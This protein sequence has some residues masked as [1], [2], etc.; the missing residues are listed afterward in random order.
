MRI[1]LV[2]VAGAL[3]ALCR[4]AVGL[5]AGSAAFPWATLAI[6]VAGS[7][8]LAALLAVAPVPRGDVTVALG[9]GFLGAFTTFSTFSVE[10]LA[11]LRDGRAGA[12]AAYVAASMVLGVAAAGAGWLVGDR[13]V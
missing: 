12:A 13:L 4:Y 11:L 3:G 8:L 10:T 2:A 7:F 1:L 6:N 9:T 5:A